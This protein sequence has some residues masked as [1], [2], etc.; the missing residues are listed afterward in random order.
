M[1]A[2]EWKRLVLR[3]GVLYRRVEDDSVRWQ[4]VPVSH[5]KQAL[6]GV[7]DELFHTHYDDAIIHLRMRFFCHIWLGI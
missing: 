3:E 1:F 2:R 5:R 4:V 6:V 7:H